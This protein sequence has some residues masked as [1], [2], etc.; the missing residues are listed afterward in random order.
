MFNL[1]VFFNV[2]ILKILFKIIVKIFNPF[3]FKIYLS[4]I[5][6]NDCTTV[7]CIGVIVKPNW[8]KVWK[9]NILKN[10]NLLTTNVSHHIET[11]KLI[12]NLNQ[13]TGTYMVVN[14]LTIITIFYL[15]RRSP[16]TSDFVKRV[17]YIN[18]WKEKTI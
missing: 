10:V 12:G 8:N 15:P 3:K 17:K 6:Y 18:H 1:F 14:G 11:S 13:L 5:P 16:Y 7:F 4:I 2:Q 9:K